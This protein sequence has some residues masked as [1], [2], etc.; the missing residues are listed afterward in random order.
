[1]TAT[2]VHADNVPP[3]LAAAAV[4]PLSAPSAPEPSSQARHRNTVRAMTLRVVVSHH[5][6]LLAGRQAV[7]KS[8][9]PSD[10]DGVRA[11]GRQCEPESPMGC[12]T[13]LLRAMESDHHGK[14]QAPGSLPLGRCPLTFGG[15][16][17]AL[18]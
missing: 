13:C 15:E 17:A 2:S 7:R 8:W 11:A 18:H 3:E 10:A 16:P 14:H 6:Q 12:R 5:D 4:P 1:M 9:K